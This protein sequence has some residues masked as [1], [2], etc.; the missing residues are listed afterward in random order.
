MTSPKFEP[1][2]QRLFHARTN[3]G[4]SAADVKRRAG[5]SLQRQKWYEMGEVLPTY[6]TL[7]DLAQG[8]D[9]SLDYLCGTAAEPKRAGKRERDAQF[10]ERLRE[11]RLAR[12]LS[13]DDLAAA[14]STNRAHVSRLERGW[15]PAYWTII[16]A[17]TRLDVS[18]DYLCGFG[19]GVCAA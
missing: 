13:Q 2:S 11:A 4:L 7:L 12:K 3:R 6:K 1:F 16:E 5:I 14:M 18:V 8:L 15:L 17:A 19:E 9:V 10:G